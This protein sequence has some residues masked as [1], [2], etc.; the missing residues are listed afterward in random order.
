VSNTQIKIYVVKTELLK[1]RECVYSEQ[2]RLNALNIMDAL[3]NDLIVLY[4]GLSVHPTFSGYWLNK[5]SIET[6]VNEIWE[7]LT[8]KKTY[9]ATVKQL[10]KIV[11]SIKL[12]T[13][14]KSQLITL[15]ESVE[16]IYIT[17]SLI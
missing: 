14:Q 4:G 12:L 1:K 11:L 6:D 13:K 10:N 16:P 2:L 7:I 8:D 15:N 3:R 5:L 17:E 9:E